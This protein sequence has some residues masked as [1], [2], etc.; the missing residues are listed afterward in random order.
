MDAQE[1]SRIGAALREFA[2]ARLNAPFYAADCTHRFSLCVCQGCDGVAWELSVDRHLGDAP[3]DFLGVV[4]ATCDAC[5]K[6]VTLLSITSPG[7]EAGRSEPER[8]KCD[9]GSRVFYAGTCDRWEDWG[10][11]DEGTMVAMCGACGS[12]RVV[13]DTD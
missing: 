6:A 3:G 10:F 13:V 1:R 4:Q 9:C 2:E 12:L 11:F 8:P 5:L 7:R